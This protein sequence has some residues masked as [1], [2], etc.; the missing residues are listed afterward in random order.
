MQHGLFGAGA[1]DIGCNDDLVGTVNRCLCRIALH[2]AFA[3]GQ[4][5]AVG[6]SDV[7]LEF[8]AFTAAAFGGAGQEFAGAGSSTILS[9]TRGS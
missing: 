3:G 6:I 2:D 4:L 7:G 9:M 8:F 5:G 1:Y